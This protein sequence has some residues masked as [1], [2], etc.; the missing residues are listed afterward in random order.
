MKK[1]IERSGCENSFFSMISTFL[2]VKWIQ[3]VNGDSIWI[4]LDWPRVFGYSVN[5]HQIC[6]RASFDEAS[7]SGLRRMHPFHTSNKKNDATAN[8]SEDKNL[9][10]CQA[11]CAISQ[12]WIGCVLFTKKNRVQHTQM[13][14]CSEFDGYQLRRIRGKC[15]KIYLKWQERKQIEVAT[16]FRCG[17]SCF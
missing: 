2:N 16:A 6:N 17:L 8:F 1:E 15:F 3:K 12:P 5:M 14:G 10:H 4:F 13:R 11:W 7:A 9:W